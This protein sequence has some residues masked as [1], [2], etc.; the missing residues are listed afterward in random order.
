MHVAGTG[1]TWRGLRCRLCV[2]GLFCPYFWSP[3]VHSGQPVNPTT[4]PPGT[5]DL[6][7]FSSESCSHAI[8]VTSGTQCDSDRLQQHFFIHRFGHNREWAVLKG[9]LRRLAA[10]WPAT[11]TTG[12]PEFLEQISPRTSPPCVPGITKS[13]RTT[14]GGSSSTLAN[15]VEHHTAI[16]FIPQQGVRNVERGYEVSMQI[17]NGQIRLRTARYIAAACA[18]LACRAV[19]RHAGKGWGG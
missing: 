16:G 17:D 12:V 11:M 3:D 7:C 6:Q 1:P 5:S 2:A 9:T 10:G 4:R 15:A 14:P 18:R 13:S 8:S 19:A